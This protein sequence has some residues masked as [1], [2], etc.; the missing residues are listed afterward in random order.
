ME[1][2]NWAARATGAL[3]P[4]GQGGLE[5]LVY[6]SVQPGDYIRPRGQDFREGEV[7]HIPFLVQMKTSG[8]MLLSHPADIKRRYREMVAE[9]AQTMLVELCRGVPEE[10][11]RAFI[12]VA[13]EYE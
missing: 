10:N 8:E 5:V 12:E 7:L 4:S 3:D 6:R 2:T 9:G 13:R 1:D 11:V